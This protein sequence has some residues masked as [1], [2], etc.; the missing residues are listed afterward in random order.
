MPWPS[1]RM[2]SG[3]AGSP[4]PPDSVEW[5]VEVRTPRI[6]CFVILCG[7]QM[8]HKSLLVAARPQDRDPRREGFPVHEACF[9]RR[10]ALG[11]RQ[12]PPSSFRSSG[13]R[14]FPAIASVDRGATSEFDAKL[15]AYAGFRIP[16]HEPGLSAGAPSRPMPRVKGRVP[17]AADK[18]G[19][20]CLKSPGGRSLRDVAR[21]PSNSSRLRWRS[22]RFPTAR[23]RCRRPGCST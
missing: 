8:A 5:R 2:R 17:R 1:W 19:T 3:R 10:A 11:G 14:D 13:G 4:V 21:G 16:P 9:P 6:R 12:S 20:W 15:R 22:K 18:S 7:G 23:T